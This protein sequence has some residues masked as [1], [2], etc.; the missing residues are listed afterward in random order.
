ML[1]RNREVEGYCQMSRRSILWSDIDQP[2]W[3]RIPVTCDVGDIMSISAVQVSVLIWQLMCCQVIKC[4]RAKP[5]SRC[6]HLFA[7]TL[8]FSVFWWL[9]A[10]CN[11]CES[12]FQLKDSY[13][14]TKLKFRVKKCKCWF[15]FFALMDARIFLKK[16]KLVK[17]SRTSI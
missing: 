2:C 7:M 9:H 17:M 6:R 5:A 14:S 12:P 8:V 1:T 13:L 11:C 15:C 16:L 10:F 4:V 3:D